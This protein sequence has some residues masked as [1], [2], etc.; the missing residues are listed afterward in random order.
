MS[1]EDRNR[2]IEWIGQTFRFSNTYLKLSQWLAKCIFKAYNPD[3]DSEGIPQVDSY[4]FI[5]VFHLTTLSRTSRVQTALS[6]RV[7]AVQ[8]LRA[9]YDLLN[10][11]C[12]KSDL[13]S[14]ASTILGQLWKYLPLTP[15]RPPS[16]QLSSQHNCRVVI[17]VNESVDW[18]GRPLNQVMAANGFL[19]GEGENRT[20]MA[21]DGRGRFLKRGGPISYA[22][23]V[24]WKL[25][26]FWLSS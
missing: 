4:F 26:L 11:W 18:K 23:L 6:A 8:C 21:T 16:S 9:R 2:H 10:T 25:S 15:L 17:W 19:G 22:L 14:K 7:D 1:R 12:R 20:G 24:S 5:C 13:I 3:P